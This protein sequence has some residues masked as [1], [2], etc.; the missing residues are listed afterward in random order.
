MLAFSG[1]TTCPGAWQSRKRDG[2]RVTEEV[3]SGNWGI[4]GF[5]DEM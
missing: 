3:G 5:K 2:E 1:G 4:S